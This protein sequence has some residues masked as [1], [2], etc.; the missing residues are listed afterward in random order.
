VTSGLSPIDDSFAWRCG[1]DF[2]FR[3][4]LNLLNLLDL[5]Y[6]FLDPNERSAGPGRYVIASRVVIL[7]EPAFCLCNLF[8]MGI[9]LNKLICNVDESWAGVAPKTGQFHAH[10]LVR[11]GIYRISK[12]FVAGDEH[13]RVV[14]V[15]E[16]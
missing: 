15:G 4:L 10:T 2:R 11:N 13:R 12:V 9:K 3:H 7:I 8:E 5:L 14:F 6:L 16:R 1:L